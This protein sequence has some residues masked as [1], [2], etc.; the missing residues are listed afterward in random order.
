M[1]AD[2][3]AN[4]DTIKIAL[5]YGPQT[6]VRSSGNWG[7]S[8]RAPAKYAKPMRFRASSMGWVFVSFLL[9]TGLMTDKRYAKPMS[10]GVAVLYLNRLGRGTK[11]NTENVKDRESKLRYELPGRGQNRGSTGAAWLQVKGPTGELSEQVGPDLTVKIE[12]GVLT[13]WALGP[14]ESIA[15]AWRVPHS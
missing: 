3:K 9:L 15:A 14:N 1:F 13:R 11:H 6:E 2:M 10:A 4:R 12:D 7:I 5:K 8:K